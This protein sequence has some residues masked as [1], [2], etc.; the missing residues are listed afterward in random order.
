MHIALTVLLVVVFAYATALIFLNS[1]MTP[2][3][4]LFIQVPGMNLGALLILAVVLGVII[5]ML[6]AL[7]VFRVFQNRAQIN[8]LNRDLVNVN[9]DLASLRAQNEALVAQKSQAPLNKTPVD[10]PRIDIE[11]VI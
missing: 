5:G 6:L 9:R 1:A 2:V 10:T 8:R 3:N 7:V 11:P 4:L